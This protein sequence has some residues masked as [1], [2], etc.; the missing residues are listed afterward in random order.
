MEKLSKHNDVGVVTKIIQAIGWIC[1]GLQC[2]TIETLCLK[3]LIELQ[4][5]KDDE[6]QRTISEAFAFAFAK[7]SIPSDVFLVSNF[8]SL[9]TTERTVDPIDAPE[10]HGDIHGVICESL[11]EGFAHNRFHHRS[12]CLNHV[13]SLLIYCPRHPEI[14]SRLERFQIAFLGLLKDKSGSI[15]E[16]ASRGVSLIYQLADPDVKTKL[17]TK[18]TSLLKDSSSSRGANQE[19]DREGDAEEAEGSKLLGGEHLTL[20]RIL[21]SLAIDMEQPDLLYRFMDFTHPQSLKEIPK[22]TIQD[23][24]DVLHKVVPKMYR[25]QFDPLPAVQS[26]M[27]SLWQNLVQDPKNIIETCLPFILQ[28][29]I[30]GLSS[31]FWR[32]R[33]SSCQALTELLP[34]QKWTSI[35]PVF[36]ELWRLALRVADDIKESVLLAGRKLLKILKRITLKYSD[37]NTTSASTIFKT[38]EIVLPVLLNVIQHPPN[39]GLGALALSTLTEIAKLS[40][41]DAL[42]PHLTSLVASL[43]ENLNVVE[44]SSLDQLQLQMQG[45]GIETESFDALRD[46]LFSQSPIQEILDRCTNAVNL[47]VLEKGELISKLKEGIQRG[48]GTNNKLGIAR[49]VAKMV[50][51]LGAE[52]GPFVSKL[53]NPL[54]QRCLSG[55]SNA[56]VLKAYAST[57]GILCK[58]GSIA[59]TE[60]V[61]KGCLAAIET[62]GGNLKAV[63][64]IL[65]EV[66]S[67]APTSFSNHASKILPIAFLYR[68]MEEDAA[69][70]VWGSLLEDVTES[71]ILRLYGKEIVETIREAM[72]RPQ[73]SMKIL[74][75]QAIQRMFEMDAQ[76]VTD[77]AE[78][79]LELLLEQLPGKLWDGKETLFKGIVRIVLKTPQV[80]RTHLMTVVEA[81]ETACSKE[82]SI[83]R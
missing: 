83:Y 61:V 25:L 81:L 71:G 21:N 46:R 70:Q 67:Q 76:S 18:L 69:A 22:L 26:T 79:L 9:K 30:T 4:N 3:H 32:N 60:R 5:V 20:Y 58:V 63:G 39:P 62:E 38:V 13:I 17:L 55:E 65:K 66:Q 16:R 36:A 23:R 14:L 78:S 52:C 10:V 68:S 29:L 27:Q 57:L 1:K 80:A 64:R 7:Q 28:E 34:L 6:I 19:I 8:N 15:Q 42:R 48:V 49:F 53:M 41:V 73:W 77:F 35:Q 54:L 82:K 72:A 12:A 40:P 43:L 59:S 2:P 24:K 47:E 31:R 37:P 56:A 50:N 45:K 44:Y 74:A 75:G 51:R 33:E 11:L